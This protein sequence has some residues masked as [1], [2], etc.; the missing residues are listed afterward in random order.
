[1]CTRVTSCFLFV[2]A[3]GVVPLGAQIPQASGRI[4][5]TVLDQ[6]NAISLPGVPVTLLGTDE[7]VY[8]D[9]DGRYRLD[10][11]P[12]TH[13]LR[14]EMSGY[15]EQIVRVTVA[16]GQ[17]IEMQ[18]AL[19]SNRFSEAVTV[20][21]QVVDAETSTA[22]AQLVL[23]RNAPVIT[24]NLGAQEMRANGDSNAAVAMTRITGVSLVDNQFVYVRGL[25]E[26]YSNT[27]LSG[28]TLPTT[29]PDKKVVP[30]D[31]FP[32]GLLDSV[33]VAKSY[34][35]DKSAEFAG[36]LVQI[37]PLKFPS[38]GHFTL[39][40]E[41]SR[42][43]LATGNSIPLSPLGSRDFWGYDNGSRALP[44]SFPADKI[45]RRGIFTPDVGFGPEEI[46]QFGRAL[47]NRWVPEARSG[48]PGQSWG[49][50]YGNRFGRLGI[51][52]SLRH[53]YREQ[54][55][56]ENRKFFIIDNTGDLDIFSDYDFQV[57]S[58]KAQ[59]GIV[60]NA[61][62]QFT[63]N[64][65]LSLENFYSHNGRDEGRIFEGPNTDR[66]F[67]LRN[68]RL[69]FIEEGLF[70]NAA[71]GEHF[72]PGWRNSL[73][74][75]RVSSSRATRDEPDLRE[76]LYFQ[77]IDPVTGVGTGAFRLADATQSG[78]RLFNILADDTI[79]LSINWSSYATVGPLPLQLRFGPSYVRRTRDFAS[80]RFRFVPT[81]A[82]PVDLTR[83]PE[84]ILA[85][86]NIGVDF[87]F[88]EDTRPTD[89]YDA[90][91]ETTA[92]YGMTDLSLSSRTRLVAG[93]RVERF[94]LTV[95]T[96]DP[97]GL[98]VDRITAT[99]RDTDLFPAVNL[100]YAIRPDTNLRVSYSQTVNR[101]EF[102]ELA[103]F[104]FTDVV[105]NKAVRGNPDLTRALIR[106]VDARVERFGGGRSVMAASV[107]YKGF[108]DPI[109]RVVSAGA[110]P[111]TSFE[112]ADSARNFGLELEIGRQFGRSV[113]VS[114]NYTY[115]DS[116]IRLTEAARRVQTSLVRPLAGQSKHLFNVMG[117]FTTSGF[118]SRVLYSYFG[119]R[120]SD[121][122]SNGTP[123]VVEDGRGLLDVV[124]AQRLAQRL[125][126]RL[127]MENLTNADYTFL[128]GFQAQ[129]FYRAGRTV[130]LSLGLTVF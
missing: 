72:V 109:E 83:S 14:I 114:G 33:Q 51:V 118:T 101:P 5:G 46:T 11:A 47:E 16:S 40:L 63:S 71:S 13:E 3:A 100:V 85:P 35:P 58:Q 94:D 127:T 77:N 26:R 66:N 50:T 43:S 52:T 67:I 113:F 84:A 44:A 81:N 49:A 21:G 119:D 102:R 110:Q 55:V 31:L 87:R 89:A 29:E 124:I 53:S 88:N 37:V 108:D 86:E 59:L 61:A 57:G 129:R 64:H 125:G 122:G 32:A 8:T 82:R 78:F 6:A 76:T 107:F 27:T 30:L 70:S 45:V 92:F 99:L 115:V 105:G 24:D 17:T 60:G 20:Q 79:D 103:A 104:E 39:S 130:G 75:W 116:E 95:N 123:D 7:L 128:Q 65:R 120:I 2:L 1:M 12:G 98:F 97:F 22:A 41:A 121:V 23:R 15:A 111:L 68:Y 112:N 19:A 126:L 73:F 28:S 93:A 56:E 48:R 106:N 54:Y 69:Q 18:V 10:V 62:Y 117:E 38:H 36:G 34:S 90:I 96:F 4:A 25:G 9:L 91:S 80:R 42:S 74:D